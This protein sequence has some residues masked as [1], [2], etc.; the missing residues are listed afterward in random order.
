MTRLTRKRVDAEKRGFAHP[1][2]L[3]Q[4]DTISSDLSQ[5]A[6]L[7]LADIAKGR[8]EAS[9]ALANDFQDRPKRPNRNHPLQAAE[10][11]RRV[12]A[13]IAVGDAACFIALAR[14]LEI[15]RAAA[16][17]D[18]PSLDAGLS[19]LV[20]ATR[21]GSLPERS[22]ACVE[23]LLTLPTA[24]SGTD[25]SRTRRALGVA[26]LFRA[27][28]LLRWCVPTRSSPDV[29][30]IIPTI[31]EHFAGVEAVAIRRG[32]VPRVVDGTQ[33]LSKVTNLLEA[34]PDAD[35]PAQPK[36]LGDTDAVGFDDVIEAPPCPA[37]AA[38]TASVQATIL[39]TRGVAN[40]LM[41][42]P[43]ATFDP[44]RLS[45]RRTL[46]AGR[47][48]VLGTRMPLVA[49]PLRDAA[50]TALS[51]LLAEMPNF[52][53]VLDR[54]G[55]ELALARRVA[56]RAALRLPP[57]LLCGPPGVG[58]TRFARRLA[59]CLGVSYACLAVAGSADNRALAGTARGWSSTHPAWPVEQLAG[60]RIGNPLLVIDE[61]DK[62][63]GGELNGRVVATLLTMLEPS[64][65]AVFTDEC[66]GG[67]VDLSRINWLLTA[68][69]VSDLP[70]PFLSR[71]V[72][73]NVL[74][75][76]A[77]NAAT[78]VATMR[79]DLAEERGLADPLLLPALSTDVAA[80]LATDY[81]THRDPRR[82][83]AELLRALGTAARAEERATA[84][85]TPVLN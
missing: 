60:L 48:A 57:L 4:R 28:R 41:M 15:D 46:L 24:I 8:A 61:V 7:M 21:T 16:R 72:V 45:E 68:N 43:F 40:P 47:F 44:D 37:P 39:D 22:V 80:G 65:A 3:W 79:R 56:S 42:T 34:R 52:V 67:P 19:A 63:G 33:L 18:A 26:A 84:G 77:G 25:M 29:P 73:V 54:I 11:W 38:A 85:P 32:L 59:E 30:R 6:R 23:L 69:D 10:R 55:D 5:R 81:A 35:H 51:A 76:E 2:L 75:P 62:A 31:M 70:A 50:D 12:A 14:G 58:K 49:A 64:T 74:P 71:V 20:L 36:E 66:L 82:L 78:L 17:L 9:M 13:G 27:Y 1:L 83:R 53:G